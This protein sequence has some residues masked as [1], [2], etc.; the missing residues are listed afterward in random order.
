MLVPPFFWR[1]R[2][3]VY[4]P[5]FMDPA[6]FLLRPGKRQHQRL[7][8]ANSSGL[9]STSRLFYIRDKTTGTRF[10]IDTG[11]EVSILPAGNRRVAVE[12]PTSVRLQAVNRSIIPTYGQKSL[13]LELGLRRIF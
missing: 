9:T 4:Q 7:A 2:Q 11:A 13:T 1:Q 10:L 5:M 8:A 3:E 6:R 12:Q